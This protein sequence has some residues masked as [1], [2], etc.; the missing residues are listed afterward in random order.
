MIK[1]EK[2]LPENRP[3]AMAEVKR[4][5]N[6]IL[7]S[8][9]GKDLVPA[10]PPSKDMQA[11]TRTL[12]SHIQTILQKEGAGLA[13]IVDLT[14]FLSKEEDMEAYLETFE[15]FFAVK[16]PGHKAV[17]VKQESRLDL[18][19]VAYREGESSMPTF[20]QSGSIGFGQ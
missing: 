14:A 10:N 4:V 9:S 11:Y 19:V 15:A 5:G 13:D 1:T 12:L 16:K 17:S 3:E 18:K 20:R 2:K 6:L 8:G 7:I